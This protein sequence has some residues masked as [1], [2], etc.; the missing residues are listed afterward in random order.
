M[1][2]SHR[3]V[4]STCRLFYLDVSLKW[5]NLVVKKKSFKYKGS[6]PKCLRECLTCLS[7][8]CDLIARHLSEF[9]RLFLSSVESDKHFQSVIQLI[10]KQISKTRGRHCSL[11]IACLTLQ[12]IRGNQTTV[13]D[14]LF[15][16]CVARVRRYESYPK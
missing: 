15:D 9:S 11:E 6:V 10:L 7:I 5:H 14:A 16:L 8:F 4:Y 12:M 13:S 1:N 2:N 3:Y